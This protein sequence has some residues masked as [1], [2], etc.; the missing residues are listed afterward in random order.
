M[1]GRL[2]RSALRTQGPSLF[3]PVKGANGGGVLYR[4]LYF[5]SLSDHQ[6][7]GIQ[8]SPR[9]R[10]PLHPSIK[11]P[12]SKHVG[13]WSIAPPSLPV[14]LLPSHLKTR[15]PV[16]NGNISEAR[17]RKVFLAK[18]ALNQAML[19]TEASTVYKPMWA[20]PKL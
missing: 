19:F 15:G 8:R 7:A 11:S 6:S 4:M 9:Y 2:V 1:G 14:T 18:C 13:L 17:K 20:A 12:S 3:V 5:G 10:I 16:I